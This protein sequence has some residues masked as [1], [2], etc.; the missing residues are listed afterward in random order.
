[1]TDAPPPG[2]ATPLEPPRTVG[3]ILRRI[4]PGIIITGS[5]VG[6][7]E[8][9]V[10]T[11]LGS[12]AG[13]TLLWLILFSCFIKVFLQIELGRY[14]I[15]SGKSALLAFDQIPGPALELGP[16]FRVHWLNGL[17][18]LMALGSVFQLSGIFLG[19]VTVFALPALG[20]ISGIGA[21]YWFAAIALVTILLLVSGRYSLVEKTTTFMVFIFSG[22]T[23][24]S[25]ALLQRSDAFRIRGEDL[26]EGLSFQLP[27]SGLM[28]AFAALG[29]TGVG[30]SELIYYPYW[31]LEKGYA[32]F[33]GPDDGTPEWKERARGWLKVLRTDAWISFGIYTIGTS[34]FYLLGA[35]VLH[36]QGIVPDDAGDMHDVLSNLYTSTFGESTGIWL[37]MVGAAAVLFSTFFVATASNARL[38]TDALGVFRIFRYEIPRNRLRTL[39]VL[40]VI[41]PLFCWLVAKYF[42]N[43]VF[44]ILLGAVAQASLLPF[45]AFAAVYLRYRRTDPALAPRSIRDVFLWIA[46]VSMLA[47][48][49]Y[50]LQ[51]T[52]R[53]DVMPLFS[54]TP[55]VEEAPDNSPAVPLEEGD[56]DES[57]D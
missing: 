34:A 18:S 47:V 8:L 37:Y 29:I 22:I 28:T 9:I 5:I 32:R 16:R 55:S 20:A 10:T 25:V 21:D 56:G 13:F 36:R 41:N 11:R 44:L 1:M 38:F 12:Q 35:A 39:Q 3:G 48:G 26:V 53:E 30:A 49:A 51:K 14:V 45:L 6:S 43:P 42:P 52:F 33:T 19:L 23:L 54:S 31:C 24:L 27:D 17:W 2:D 46:F 4:G 15:S 50:Q 7:G 57:E 40:C